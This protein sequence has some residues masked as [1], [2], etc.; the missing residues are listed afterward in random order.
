MVSTPFVPDPKYFGKDPDGIW[1][2]EI[3][4]KAGFSFGDADTLLI[5]LVVSGL[6][7]DTL[8]VMPSIS[9]EKP[10]CEPL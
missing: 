1:G 9:M 4:E 8:A 10:K 6:T 5:P 2:L 3:A 7:A